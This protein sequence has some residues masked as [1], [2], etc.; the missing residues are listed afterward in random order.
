MDAARKVRTAKNMKAHKRFSLIYSIFLL[1]FTVFTVLE[2]FVIPQTY[3][4]VAETAQETSYVEAGQQTG[5]TDSSEDGETGVIGY[6]ASDAGSGAG[7]DT[8]SDAGSDADSDAGSGTASE[9][10]STA[11]TTEI[12]DTSYYSDG[13]SIKI[14]TYYEYDTAI[15]VAD[16][17]LEDTSRLRTAFADNTYGKNITETTSDILQSTGGI[18]AINGDYYSARR[19][20]VIRNG[21]LYSETSA[22]DD[23][24]DL[25][26]WS[27][28][29]ME[30]IREGDYT[31]EELL[32]KGAQQVFCFGPGLV[33][34][35]EVAVGENEE[36]AKSMNSNPRTA[37]GQIG[38][39][40][41]VMVVSDGRTSESRGLSLYQLAEFMEGLGCQTAYNLDGGGSSTMVFNGTVI[42]KP[43][44][45]GNN[46]K[47]RSVSDIVYIY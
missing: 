9:A 32:N 17:I 34:N 21:V 7:S 33:T 15:Y 37:I 5:F 39:G 13:V 22:D 19:G 3:Q 1:A 14:S 31:A 24:E 36:V 38:E 42:N 41:Y 28:G 30:V 46:I 23:Q 20:Y 29:S 11:A 4:V 43:T 44:T 25:V 2:T 35:G 8:T 47:E 18:L 10:A 40:H 27:D 6:I 16:I 45:N 26:I 12:T